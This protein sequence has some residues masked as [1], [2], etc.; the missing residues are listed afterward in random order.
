MYLFGDPALPRKNLAAG[1]FL[2]VLTSF[3]GGATIERLI[4]NHNARSVGY[5]FLV[6]WIALWLAAITIFRVGLTSL[7]PDPRK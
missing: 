6:I 2:L 4:W 3:E 5:V 1:A 7:P